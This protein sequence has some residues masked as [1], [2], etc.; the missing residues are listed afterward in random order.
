MGWWWGLE[1]EEVVEEARDVEADG[2]AFEEE[3]AEEGEVLGEELVVGLLAGVPSQHEQ[4]YETEVT[5]HLFLPVDLIETVCL[6]VI[7][8]PSRN[9]ISELAVSL[10]TR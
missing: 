6:L 3:L 10:P 5:H 7:D 4:T 2:L 1:D 9:G 8:Q